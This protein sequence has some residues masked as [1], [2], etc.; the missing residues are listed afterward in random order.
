[1][2]ERGGRA[3]STKGA[4]REAGLVALGLGFGQGWEGAFEL[5]LRLGQ[6]LLAA[7]DLEQ[8]ALVECLE[9]LSCEAL[10]MLTCV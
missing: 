4:Y 1:M 3:H 2:E 10:E 8:D 5:P 9:K 6:G 7:D